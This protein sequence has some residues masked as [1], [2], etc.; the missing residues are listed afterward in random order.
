M[1]ANR[2]S[3]SPVMSSPQ[4]MLVTSKS[5]EC[6]SNTLPPTPALLMPSEVKKGS[7]K[8]VQLPMSRIRTVM[9]CAPDVNNINQDCV[10]L[11]ARA[12][13][14]NNLKQPGMCAHV[15]ILQHLEVISYGLIVY[16]STNG[17][18]SKQYCADCVSKTKQLNEK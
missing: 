17:D 1:A 5:S 12:T 7:P 8:S 9:K 15:G 6:D 18:L 13:V 4:R 14:S 11:M 10:V 3:T 16:G 2:P